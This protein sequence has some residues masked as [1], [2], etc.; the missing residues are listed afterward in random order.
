MR[1][2]SLLALFALW[3]PSSALAATADIVID[4]SGISFSTTT[5]YEG[6][7]VRVYARIRNIGEV[8]M[9]AT[10]FFY[11]SD[12]LLGKAQP[13]S[14]RA[15][16]AAEEVF[17]D[18]TVPSSAFNI[19]A[20]VQ[21]TSPD[22]E[23]LAN[24]EATTPLYTPLA[25]SDADGV[26]D[27]ADN[28]PDVANDSQTDTDGDAV[29]DACDTDDDADGLTDAQEAA[30]QTDPLDS[31]TDDDGVNDDDDAAPDDPTRMSEEVAV[32]APVVAP[33]AARQTTTTTSPSS[34]ASSSRDSD[35]GADEDEAV[36]VGEDAAPHPTSA[37]G[38]FS[39]AQADDGT[40]PEEPAS[41]FRWSNPFLYALL[42][43]LG[44][45]FIAASVMIVLVRRKR[46]DEQV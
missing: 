34:P 46:T 35:G 1:V 39:A 23:N 18:F 24:N 14:L 6:D 44:L 13:I 2:L 42:G 12:E 11:R 25:D 26:G 40:A 43:L 5:L 16:G 27:D 22:D 3:L 37:Y 33:E 4:Q 9:T 29:G 32:A 31:D 38:I 7:D 28:C 19:R 36:A 41:F 30:Q 17:V 20:V 15:G 21:G 45:V 8:D 10:V